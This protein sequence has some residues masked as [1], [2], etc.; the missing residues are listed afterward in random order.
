[1]SHIHEKVDFTVTVYIVHNKTVL[2]RMHD[3]LK[4]WLGPGG[5]IELDEDPNQAAVREVKEEVG[6]DIVLADDGMKVRQFDQSGFKALLPPRF[7]NR[8]KIKESH[9]HIDSVYFAKTENNNISPA[10]G[11]A[12][13]ET[14][15]FTKEELND[16]SYGIHANVKYYAEKALETLS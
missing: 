10:P 3:K 13:T 9:E 11:E 7:L 5:H 16:P 12:Q 1:M 14:H 6:I 15:W 2:L 4:I 8:H